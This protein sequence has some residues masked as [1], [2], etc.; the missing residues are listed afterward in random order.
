MAPTAP[1]K[2][3]GCVVE[4]G[5]RPAQPRTDVRSD[6]CWWRNSGERQPRHHLFVKCRAWE[7]QIRELWR[8]ESDS[9][10]FVFFAGC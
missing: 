2:P 8:D 5:F 6:M 10:G 4:A 3:S 9:G 7:V 1:S